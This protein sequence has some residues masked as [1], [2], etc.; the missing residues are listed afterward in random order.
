MQK[1]KLVEEIR[2]R[3]NKLWK[4]YNFNLNKICTHLKK[5]NKKIKNL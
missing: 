3:A 5:R 2:I 1:D 4:K